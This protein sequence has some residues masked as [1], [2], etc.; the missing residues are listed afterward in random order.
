MRVLQREARRQQVALVEIEDG[1]IEQ[2]Q[3]ARIDEHLGA[4]RALEDLVGGARRRRPN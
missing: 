4:A 2:L 3:T 1:A